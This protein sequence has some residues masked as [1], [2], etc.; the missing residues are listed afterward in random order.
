[1]GNS[2]RMNSLLELHPSQLLSG[3]FAGFILLGTILLKLPFA[4]H[5]GISVMDALFTATSAACVTGL[6]VVD[7]G[8]TFTFF[9]Q[10]V[11]LALIQ[12]GG[13]G[14]MTFSVFF[15]FVLGR[16]LSMR[17]SSI[18][19]D[20]FDPFHQL[21]IK[22]LLT[23]VI[24]LTFVIE[25]VGFLFLAARWIP[26]MGIEKGTYYAI[27]H[28]VSGFCNA[29]ICLFPDSLISYSGDLT[30]NMVFGA[31]IV[32]GSLGFVTLVEVSMVSVRK[33]AGKRIG[34]SLQTR[35]IFTVSTALILTGALL[36]FFIE[37]SNVFVG[38]SFVDK[39][40]AS[41]FHSVSR[42]AGFITVDFHEFSNG[43]LFLYIMLMFVGAA[44]GSVGGGIK[45][46][47]FG[48]LIA[49]GIS[50]LYSRE[51]VFAFNRTIPEEITSRSISILFVS[52]QIIVLFTFILLLTE[53]GP[54]DSDSHRDKFMQIMFEVVS[55]FGTVGLSAGA[56]SELTEIGKGLITLLMLIGRLGPLTVTMAVARKASKGIYHY[57]EE[58]VMV[59]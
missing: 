15:S 28:A 12:V 56:T 44:P 50:R 21:S 10:L 39:L 53:S 24:K 6:M 35:M 43:S 38:M 51:K 22:E 55:A 25:I 46:T 49:M 23:R 13:L 29:G 32:A 37:E 40:M 16:A 48:V 45:V 34:F 59:G 9:G 30:V 47:T 14:I 33:M 17:E 8:T 11:I 54:T 41:L 27:F 31:L 5:D 2:K 3:V 58:N 18:V 20:S 4:T 7:T 1:M 42:T 52:V 36:T 57:S 26:E 19:F